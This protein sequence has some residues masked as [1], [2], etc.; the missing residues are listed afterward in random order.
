MEIGSLA[1]ERS[2]HE[3]LAVIGAVPRASKRRSRLCLS[4]PSACLGGAEMPDQG[5]KSQCFR[6]CF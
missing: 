4:H 6:V 3:P 1:G 5:L 2:M